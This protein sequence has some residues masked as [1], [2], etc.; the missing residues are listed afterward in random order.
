LF[1]HFILCCLVI[2]ARSGV[3][4][5]ESLVGFVWVDLRNLSVLHVSAV[6]VPVGRVF[7]PSARVPV[8][9]WAEVVFSVSPRCGH[10]APV[11]F[12]FLA[13]ISRLIFMFAR[14]SLGQRSA[15]MS[16]AFPNQRAC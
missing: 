9:C 12:S 5:V 10:S 2:C 13:R 1:S 8:P 15:G 16:F 3:F 7:R 6:F 14:K 4:L 11:S